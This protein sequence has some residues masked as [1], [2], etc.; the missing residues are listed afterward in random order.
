MKLFN[1]NE[2]FNTIKITESH[3]LTPLGSI[4]LSLNTNTLDTNKVAV[5]NT[6]CLPG[7]GYI[8]CWDTE[9]IDAELMI[10]PFMPRLPDDMKID[11][12][13]A[14]V[15]RV[16][17]KVNEVNC[18]FSAEWEEGY[19][20]DDGGA[21]SGQYLES[22]AWENKDIKVSLG[23]E[24]GEALIIRSEKNYF[25][26]VTYN[27]NTNPYTIVQYFDKGLKVPINNLRANEICQIHFVIA[28]SKNIQY[29][30]STWYA[31]DVLPS[32]L[33]S[34]GDVW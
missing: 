31:V 26:P 33:L 3:V 9:F 4:C 2:N 30:T 1:S 22:Q 15:W 28:W 19:V 23:T 12:G 21:E 34:A 7:G 16:R 32:D 29:D 25:M 18:S 5:T 20:W 27:E 6:F 13:Y 10:I 17:C 8:L 14:A 11:G 24:D